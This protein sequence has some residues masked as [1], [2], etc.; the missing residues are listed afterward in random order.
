M[1]PIRQMIAEREMNLPAGTNAYRISDGT[2]WPGI[3]IDAM[4]D[5]L[6]VSVR[7]T[8]VPRELRNQLAELKRPVYLK[9][10]DRDVKLPP[11]R[12]SGPVVAPRFIIAENGVRY[13]ID[14]EA[15]YSQGIF[16]DQRDNRARVRSRCREGMTLL[17]TFAYTGAFSVCAALA[18][19]QT[20]TLDLSPSCLNWCKENMVLNGIDPDDHYFCKG[21]TMHWLDRFTRQGRRFDAIVLDPP[22]FSRDEKGHVWRAEKDYGRLVESALKCLNPGGWL[23]C[24][25]NCR[26]LSHGAFYAQVSGAAPGARLTEGAMSFDFDGEPYLKIIWVDC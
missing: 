2:T 25:T 15:G 14:M 7:D 4:A 23:L 10:L 6:L 19:A 16:L 13:L 3:F 22:T 21:D 9:R 1:N 20:T 17:N 12:L 18:G 5:R 8:E 24:T 26:K 11:Q